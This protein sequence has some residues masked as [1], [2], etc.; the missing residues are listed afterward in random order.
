[1]VIQGKFTGGS[2]FNVVHL[3]APVGSVTDGNGPSNPS[4]DIKYGSGYIK[5][6]IT[7]STG[8]TDLKLR[9]IGFRAPGQSWQTTAF[10]DPPSL[11]A[12]QSTIIDLTIEGVFAGDTVQIHPAKHTT[13]MTYYAHVLETPLSTVQVTITNSDSSTKNA[14]SGT[15]YLTITKRAG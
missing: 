9:G 2:N 6:L 7:Q 15:Y 13:Y 3:R 5:P 1:V 4:L 11:A 14:V 10:I 12:G 8:I